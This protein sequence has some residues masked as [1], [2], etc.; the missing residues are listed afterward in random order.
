MIRRFYA[1]CAY[2]YFP[3]TRKID[4]SK[5]QIER[6]EANGD[7]TIARPLGGVYWTEAEAERAASIANLGNS[8]MFELTTAS[9]REPRRDRKRG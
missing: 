7:K 6:F 4:D 2:A 8:T 3:G 9:G 1:R 5:W